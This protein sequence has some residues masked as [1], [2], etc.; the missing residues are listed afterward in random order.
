[1][2]SLRKVFFA[3][4]AAI[5]MAASGAASAQNTHVMTV[6]VPGGIAQ[7]RYVGDVPPQIVVVPAP[8]ASPAAFGA[9]LPIS[10]V[11]GSDSP[12]AMMDRIAA[13]MDRRAAAMFRYAEAM[14]EPA[15]AGRIAQITAG[16]APFGTMS[17]GGE[18]Y[19]FVST[20]SGNGACSQSVRIV[21][22][23]DGTPPL[24]ERHSSGNCG[25]AA[26]TRPG[27]PGV[28]PA[29]PVPTPLPKQPD[30][31][32]TRSA[33]SPYAGLVRQVASVR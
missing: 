5:G 2:A 30:L 3:G 12:F 6:A 15:D 26:T 13:E 7:I 27:R 21:S 25:V 1:M 16:A 33:G 14:A 32:L 24:V 23:G 18:S 8:A 29:A 20:I 9:R 17:S 22:R 4:V 10:S 19:S 28:T 31:I 11:F